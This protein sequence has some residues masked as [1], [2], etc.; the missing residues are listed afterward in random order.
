M[1]SFYA[2]LLAA[3]AS[4]PTPRPPV[5]V[6]ASTVLVRVDAVVLDG[7]DHPVTD[8]KA[9]DFE[10]VESG[11]RPPITH[12]EYVE[13]SSPVP[14]RAARTAPSGAVTLPRR[15]DVRRVVVLVAD[16]LGLSSEGMSFTK[17]ALTSFVDA[18]MGTGDL[19]AILRTGGGMGVLEQYTTDRALLR[20]SIAQLQYNGLAH[21]AKSPRE[22]VEERPGAASPEEIAL[23]G[24]R[25]A[26]LSVRKVKT[27]R[28][29]VEGLRALPGRKAMIVFSNMLSLRDDGMTIEDPDLGS[30]GTANDG[31]IADEV[32]SLTQAANRGSVVIFTIDPRSMAGELVNRAEMPSS[33]RDR[34]GAG[35]GPVLPAALAMA[36][37][38]LRFREKNEAQSGLGHL[39]GET[40]GT[41]QANITDTP[42]AMGRVM[43]DL[44]GYYRLGYVPEVEGAGARRGTY[45]QISVHVKRPG[46]KVRFR[47]GY[48]EGTDE[49]ENAP[50]PQDAVAAAAGSPFAQEGLGV[51]LSTLFGHDAEKGNLLRSI[52]HV[53][54]RDLTFAPASGGTEAAAAPPRAE[55]E[56]LAF[57]VGSKGLAG[58]TVARQVTLPA[59]AETAERLRKDGL[60]LELSLPVK[61]P[62]SYQVRAVVRDTH[63]KKVG[64]AARYVVVPDLA[65]SRLALSGLVLS[66]PQV[67]VGGELTYAFIVF[68]PKLRAGADRPDLELKMRL[69]RDGQ[70]AFDGAPSPLETAKRL[71][72]KTG[73]LTQFAAGGSFR[74]GPTLAPGAYSLE[75][76]VTDR[77]AK[78]GENTA[79]EQADLQVN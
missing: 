23:E 77:L 13:V 65:K 78:K 32:R 69:L 6:R 45:H 25:Q 44:T 35:G 73:K 50:S 55:L 34:T 18:H 4:A 54:G 42:S 2:V 47:K 9:E 46:L 68:N 66:S 30:P 61:D 51:T 19:V 26:V 59:S 72:D 56:L 39:A 5:V 75:V 10:I 36:E 1:P 14:P 28:A 11:R 7:K 22:I 24:Q 21:Q 60:E 71:E 20:A 62:G 57:A 64:T 63:S 40:G 41:F 38:R 67:A 31:G 15:E 43:S 53:D 79:V 16:D 58:D 74:V 70:V 52:V 33:R 76:V 49:D 48:F 3:A 29:V 8:L 27:L 37:R 12:C 17:E